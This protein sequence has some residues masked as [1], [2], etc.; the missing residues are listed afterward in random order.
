MLVIQSISDYTNSEPCLDAE[1]NSGIDRPYIAIN[2]KGDISYLRTRNTYRLALHVSVFSKG[3]TPCFVF[4]LLYS[5]TGRM[6]N[7]YRCLI[8][9]MFVWIVIP[10][11]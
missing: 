3:I 4:C 5:S 8:Q 9:V 7:I 1:Y 2:P 11:G 6:I 10:G